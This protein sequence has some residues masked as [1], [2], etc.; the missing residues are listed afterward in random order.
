MSQKL[1]P[2]I[3]CFPIRILCQ[4]FL[5]STFN[6]WILPYLCTRRSTYPKHDRQ[7]VDLSIQWSRST[8]R[9][10]YRWFSVGRYVGRQWLSD[11]RM[12]CRSIGY[13]HS[14]DTSLILL[15]NDVK[16]PNFKFTWER[17]R[18][19]VWIQAWSVDRATDTRLIYRAIYR[20]RGHKL[21]KILTFN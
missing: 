12:T 21:R 20:P 11:C 14:A 7:S 10:T 6:F 4:T 13:R 9:P 17:E 19:G 8:Y 2:S 18:I 3:Q 15:C 5:S 16:W 1:R